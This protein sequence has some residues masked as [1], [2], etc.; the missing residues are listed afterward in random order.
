MAKEI[1][2]TVCRKS[3][4][5]IR[6]ATLRKGIAYICAPCNQRRLD[7]LVELTRL[8]EAPAHPFDSIFGRG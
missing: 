2:C 3:M 1:K 5:E 4:G 8:K 7:A 6:D